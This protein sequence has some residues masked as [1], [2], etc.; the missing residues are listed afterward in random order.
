M[1]LALGADSGFG[2]AADEDQ[3][4]RIKVT[5]SV[6]DENTLSVCPPLNLTRDIQKS[7]SKG[8]TNNNEIVKIVGTL[9][10]GTLKRT[11]KTQRK[12]A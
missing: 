1:V 11:T 4:S 12:G 2:P 8:M 7:V 5:G 6:E 9:R 10:V 3:V